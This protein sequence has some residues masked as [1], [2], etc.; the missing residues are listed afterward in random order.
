MAIVFTQHAT[1]TTTLSVPEKEQTRQTVSRFAK[2]H[3]L[4]FTFD[5]VQPSNCCF[6]TPTARP[7]QPLVLSSKPTGF[8]VREHP[9]PLFFSNQKSENQKGQV[10]KSTKPRE[11]ENKAKQNKKERNTHTHTLWPW[12][13][14][15]TTAAPPSVLLFFFLLP[16]SKS[17]AEHIKNKIENERCF[18][19]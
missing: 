9:R 6:Q 12:R 1:T 10:L 5:K 14:A 15:A 19:V 17:Q 7:F 8:A 11:N 2:R 16:T 4:S 18:S 13:R 3:P